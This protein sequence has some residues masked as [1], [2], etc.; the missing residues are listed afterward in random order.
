MCPSLV[1]Q[2]FSGNQ[3]SEAVVQT[4]ISPP[5]RTRFL[6]FVPLDWNPSGW[7]GMRVEAF[8]CSYKSFVADF[9]GRSSL[10][11]RFHQKSLSSVRDVVSLRFRSRSP[12]GVLLHAEGQ[13]GDYFTLE[14]HRARLDLY[15]H[16]DDSRPPGRRRAAASA[17]SLLD[18]QLW[19]A[20]HIERFNRRVNLSLDAIS[21]SFLTPGEGRSLEVDYELSFGGIP[22]PGKPGT[23]LRRNFQGCLEN[24]F[25]NGINVIDL[26]QRR[27]PQI[28]TVG[29]VTFSCSQPQLPACSF[30]SASGSFLSLPAPVG[31]GVEVGGG[32]CH[33]A[34]RRRG[35]AGRRPP[36]PDLE[37]GGASAGRDAGRPKPDPDPAA[38][39]RT[40]AAER[41]RSPRQPG[42]R[43]PAA[44]RWF[45]ALGVC[46]QQPAADPGFCGRAAGRQPADGGAATAPPQLP[47]RRLPPPGLPP[48]PGAGLPGLHA[49]AVG[50][51]APGGAGP[52]AARA[53]GRIQPAAVQ[54]LQHPGQFNTCS[55]RDR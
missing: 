31:G 11:Y 4:R 32:R 52:G 29:N 41:R 40:A 14:L 12:E 3:N 37:R 5:L 35:G 8:G 34:R 39:R 55:I 17:G 22:L 18:D 7:M 28:H 26:A 50:G 10:L 21:L 53:A 47:L 2:R 49:A 19:H 30:L 45:V 6:R 23:F 43:R 36:V 13:R 33:G 44:G 9:D 54:H 25:Y 20:V 27:K 24:L 16:L 46:G 1:L 38:Q 15:L 51:G 48:P 42:R